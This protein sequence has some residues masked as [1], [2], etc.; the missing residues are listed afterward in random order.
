M[1][2]IIPKEKRYFSDMGRMNSYFLFSFA[3]YYD[4]SNEKF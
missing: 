3:D 4:P 2:K 1:I